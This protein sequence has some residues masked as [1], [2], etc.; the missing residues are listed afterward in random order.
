MTTGQAPRALPFGQDRHMPT[1]DGRTTQ[2]EHAERHIVGPKVP[3]AIRRPNPPPAINLTPGRPATY[4]DGFPETARRLCL[5]GLNDAEI[6]RFFGVAVERIGEWDAAHPEF[7]QARAHA[8]D[9]A[10]ADVAARL[11]QRAM[12]YE[13][14][15]THVG[16]SQGVAIQTPITKVYPPDVDAARWWLKNRQPGRWRDRTEVETSGSVQL[17]VLAIPMKTVIDGDA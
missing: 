13:H 8:R 5:L 4:Q 7:A 9:L 10:D 6:A 15:D 16:I 14:A 17:G 12:G 1:Q 2:A 11:Y 3:G